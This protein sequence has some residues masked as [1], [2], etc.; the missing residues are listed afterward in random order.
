MWIRKKDDFMAETQTRA[1]FTCTEAG[2]SAALSMME[3]YRKSGMPVFFYGIAEEADL[4][5]LG[6][7]NRMTHVL[8]FMDGESLKLVS[9]ADEMGGFTAEIGV[10]DLILPK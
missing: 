3:L 5:S 6:E 1:L 4:I 7:T 10:R 2:Y 9:L 8:H